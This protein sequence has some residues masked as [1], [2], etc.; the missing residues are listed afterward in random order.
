[1][2][3]I[4][5]VENNINILSDID[6]DNKYIISI[7]GDAR[8]GKSTFLNLI[9]NY[10]T[11]ENK[12]Y[13]KMDDGLSH[14]TLGIDYYIHNE[15]LFLD[16][17]GLNFLDSSNDP[18]LLLLIYSI[19]NII[20][21]ND[22]NVINNNVFTT[23]QPMAMFLNTFKSSINNSIILYFRVSDYDLDGNPKSLLDNILIE[24]DDQFNNVRESIK[25]LFSSIEI[26]ITEPI[27]KKDRINFKNRD[28]SKILEIDGF[29]N[30][31][32]EIY[33]IVNNQTRKNLNLKKLIKNINDN[34]KIDFNK[35]DLYKQNT[36]NEINEFIKEN[37]DKNEEFNVF[38]VNGY[39]QV[40]LD[41]YNQKIENLI[42]NF[43]QTFN[44]VPKKLSNEFYQKV[45]EIKDKY[46]IMKAKHY[47]L[48]IYIIE[49]IYLKYSKMLYQELNL[50]LHKVEEPVYDFT[51]ICYRLNIDIEKLDKDVVNDTMDKFEKRF[52][53]IYSQISTKYNVNL[54]LLDNYKENIKNIKV[55]LFGNIDDIYTQFQVLNINNNDEEDEEE[56][57]SNLEWIVDKMKNGNYE[58][59]VKSYNPYKSIKI[60]ETKDLEDNLVLQDNMLD[61]LENYDK[62]YNSNIDNEKLKNHYEL[63]LRQMLLAGSNNDDGI[64][65]ISNECDTLKEIINNM[66][67]KIQFVYFDTQEMGIENYEPFYILSDYFYDKL[68]EYNIPHKYLSKNKTYV[69]K[70]NNICILKNNLLTRHITA[71]FLLK[72]CDEIN[73]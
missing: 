54:L 36:I 17:Q 45:Q 52:N 59:F 56:S 64:Y 8:K 67:Y 18:K 57:K 16:C 1:M 60:P 71:E 37:I 23:L 20:I 5:F 40:E 55:D 13:F 47:K 53:E 65:I 62:N 27:D 3:L 50:L 48:S 35:L 2:K 39:N 4:N 25:K 38:V 41:N 24:Q 22:K 73:E 63:K 12:E 61:Y 21:Y 10:L 58:N 28:F 14:C 33:N 51:D 46:N 32:S 15:Y 66:E 70:S 6:L 43:K 7:V 49:P 34:K 42:N 19:S 29:G 30:I 9:I 31:I 44:K 26:N 68:K 69:S 11:R 72:L